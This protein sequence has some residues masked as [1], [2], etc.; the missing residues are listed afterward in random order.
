MNELQNFWKGIDLEC[1]G[2]VK[3]I[4][5]ALICVACDLPTG[6]KACGFLSYNAKFG[7]TKCKKDFQGT[8]G[9][10]DFSN[11]DRA[12]WPA[13]D[14]EEHRMTAKTQELKQK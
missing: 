2:V 5:C 4:R 3:T 11:F 1:G 13:R 12:N 10:F 9:S 7:C 14:G 8:V 6:R